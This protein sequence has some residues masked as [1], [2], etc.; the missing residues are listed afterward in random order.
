MSDAR[1]PNEIDAPAKPE[2]E[3]PRKVRLVVDGVPSS[4]PPGAE[5]VYPD[6]RRIPKDTRRRLEEAARPPKPPG[7][8]SRLLGR[9]GGSGRGESPDAPSSP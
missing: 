4:A 7:L 1:D 6:S 8:L 5:V 3:P 9:G 2:T